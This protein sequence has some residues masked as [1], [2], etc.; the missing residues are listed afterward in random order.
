MNREALYFSSP[1]PARKASSC[2]ADAGGK[3]GL[4]FSLSLVASQEKEGNYSFPSM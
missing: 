2:I 1:Y 4:N 3:P